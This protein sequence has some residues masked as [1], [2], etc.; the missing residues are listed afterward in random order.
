MQKTSEAEKDN[1][2]HLFTL[3]LY[4]LFVLDRKVF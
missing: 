4:L 3:D 1:N 2:E